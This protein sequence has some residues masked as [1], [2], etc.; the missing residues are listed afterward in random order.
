MARVPG[1]IIFLIVSIRTIKG[2]K[3]G[4]VPVGIK[5]VNMFWVL[6]SQPKNIK[7]NQIGKEKVRLKIKCLVE[8]KM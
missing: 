2:I 3:M 4:G 5:W 8:V 6:F 1:R 7:D